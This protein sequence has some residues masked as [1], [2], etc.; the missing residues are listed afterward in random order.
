[1]L[2]DTSGE[3]DQKKEEARQKVHWLAD[4]YVTYHGS[5]VDS[6]AWKAW[7]DATM[8]NLPVGDSAS[9]KPGGLPQST[10]TQ[11]LFAPSPEIPSALESTQTRS[12]DLGA[13]SPRPGG[14]ERMMSLLDALGEPV[15]P[16]GGAS[17]TKRSWQASLD[18]GGFSREVLMSIDTHVI[19][20]SLYIHNLQALQSAPHNIT[21]ASCLQA[22]QSDSAESEPGAPST[23]SP[24]SEAALLASS[25]SGSSQMP[26]LT[27]RRPLTM[28]AM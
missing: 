15:Q 8:P 10:S 1:M 26:A 14:G 16:K 13:F 19:A 24:L 12:P 23:S 27:E 21:V 2:V 6:A 3:D 18:Q 7:C 11:A 22:E 20:R 9:S 5:P 17:S 4:L 25:H 28:L